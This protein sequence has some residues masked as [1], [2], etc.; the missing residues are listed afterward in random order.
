[1]FSD[2]SFIVSP[3][4]D[5]FQYI[6]DVPYSIAS[7]VL[8]IL[9]AGPNQKRDLESRD[10]SFEPMTGEVCPD[11]I[12][13]PGE[14]LKPRS[15]FRTRG[16]N[17]RQTAKQTPGYVTTGKNPLHPIPKPSAIKSSR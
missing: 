12:V 1:M 8:G 17:R 3:F 5:A 9:N 16:L 7:K 14:E 11:G 2:D 4:N 15:T 13:S 6:P 10:F